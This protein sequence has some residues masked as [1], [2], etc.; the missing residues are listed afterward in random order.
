MYAQANMGHPSR[1]Q[2]FV[3]A[4]DHNADDELHLRMHVHY[5]PHQPTGYGTA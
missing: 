4:S 1:E 2:S 5:I 3:L